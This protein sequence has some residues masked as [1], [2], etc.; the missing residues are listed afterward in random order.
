ML[1]ADDEIKKIF[2]DWVMW[3]AAE[4]RYSSHTVDSY[5][6]DFRYF[7]IFISSHEGSEVT[8]AILAALELRDFRAWLSYRNNENYSFSSTARAL[9]VIRS[10]FRYAEKFYGIAN[11]AVF[12]L[13]T[14]KQKK[15]VP[16]ALSAEQ[17]A[18]ALEAIGEFA[19]EPWMAKRDIA[20]LTLIYGAGLRIAEALSLNVK[21]APMGDAMV[22]KGKGNKERMVPVLPLVTSAVREYLAECPYPIEPDSPLFVGSKSG[23]L[24]PRM[25]QR[26]IEKVRKHLGLPD[27]VTPHAFRHSFATHLLT[28]GADLRSIQ[29]LLGHASLSTTQRYTKIDSDRLLESYKKAHPRG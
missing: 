13:R 8:K 11:A 27:T 5:K 24:S 17:A 15:S 23:R 6:R 2:D 10:F 4:R 18:Q 1:A 22:I 19:S 14:P 21:D 12:Q 25:F 20:L 28:G 26:V 16:K 9:A 29:E 7:T 3:L